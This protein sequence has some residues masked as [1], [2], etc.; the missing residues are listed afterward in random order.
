MHFKWYQ[1]FWDTLFIEITT[2]KNTRFR[3][4]R[5]KI[6]SHEKKSSFP[7]WMLNNYEKI[8]FLCYYIDKVKLIF[9]YND[10]TQNEIKTWGKGYFNMLIC[11]KC[12]IYTIITCTCWKSAVIMQVRKTFTLIVHRCMPMHVFIFLTIKHV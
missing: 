1:L 3:H 8:S 11:C 4:V 5:L 7:E 6:I 12:I 10:H 2:T 9:K